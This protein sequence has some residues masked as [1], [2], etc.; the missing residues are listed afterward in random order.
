[1]DA[2]L[3]TVGAGKKTRRSENPM[4]PIRSDPK[5]RIP[6]PIFLSGADEGRVPEKSGTDTDQKNKNPWVPDLQGIFYKY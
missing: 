3:L 5:N 1:M 4:N 6:D 2:T